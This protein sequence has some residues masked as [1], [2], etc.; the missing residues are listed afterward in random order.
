MCGSGRENVEGIAREHG[1]RASRNRS[2]FGLMT[3]I[4]R[5]LDLIASGN[6]RSGLDFARP[7]PRSSGNLR[8]LICINPREEKQRVLRW[9]LIAS[10]TP[11]L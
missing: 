11:F 9:Q 10:P 1:D 5:E 2:Y 3:E 7:E 6:G 4:C 8:A